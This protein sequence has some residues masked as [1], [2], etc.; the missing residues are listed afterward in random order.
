MTKVI[1]VLYHP[2]LPEARALSG[3]LTQT[4]QD[5]G[6][7]TWVAS[8]WEEQEMKDLMSG[9]DVV[10]TIGGDGTIL[11]AAR[12][13]IPAP[14]PILGVR[15]GRLGFIAE[16]TA[17][18]ALQRAPAMVEAMDNVEVR[19]M[20]QA[21]F[22]TTQVDRALAQKQHPLMN[23]DPE[24]HAL[25]DIVVSRGATGRP[26][27]VRVLIDQQPFITYR[28]DA[29]T[30][31][32]A[33]GSTGYALSAG[34]PVLHPASRCFVLT[35]VA[36]HATLGN[37]LVLEPSMT[38]QLTVY[39]D[40]G[41]VLSIDGQGDIPIEDGDTV[42]IRQSPYSARFLRLEPGDH[43]YANLLARLHFAETI[44]R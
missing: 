33:T 24:L 43:Y 38:V 2:R 17:E 30:V 11:R 1:G 7:Q 22:A 5:R 4:L 3:E 18:E 29:V 41:A 25:N 34:G 27:Y 13:I 32:T 26:V 23:G 39:S 40:H 31:A 28:A 16:I 42:T 8:A 36:P 19:S 20:L 21:N 44:E 35:A 15:F 9:T 37:A 10:V 12:A 6:H 14:I